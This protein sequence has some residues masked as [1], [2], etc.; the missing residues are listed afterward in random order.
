MSTTRGKHRP[1]RKLA[2]VAAFAAACLFST[3]V[4][5]TPPLSVQRYS[6]EEGLSQQAVNTIV[7]DSEGFMWF[8]T[9][10]GLNRFDGYEFRQLRH[11]RSDPKT[12]P[13]GFLMGLVAAEDGV[14]IGTDG[15]GVVFRNAQT[16]TLEAPPPLRDSSDLERVRMLSRDRLGR[17]WVA[18][19]DAGVAIFDPRSY[20]LVY[21]LRREL[22]TFR[23]KSYR[24]E[25]GLGIAAM[26]TY[27]ATCRIWF[28]IYIAGC[29]VVIDRSRVIN[30]LL[31]RSGYYLSLLLKKT[32]HVP[33]SAQ[34]SIRQNLRR[35]RTLRR[36]FV[37]HT[38]STGPK[39]SYLVW[40]VNRIRNSRP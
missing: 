15:G 27:V 25:R 4:L 14:W 7:Q 36:A 11:D 6:L 24:R 2:R 10:D 31:C 34:V 23:K 39:P 1:F 5:A 32:K 28:R 18:T 12:L 33:Y 30:N 35:T 38:G 40:N 20:A 19:R 26:S 21:D 9:E 8:G 22:T 13:N 37:F 16:G 17:L 29:C 3:V